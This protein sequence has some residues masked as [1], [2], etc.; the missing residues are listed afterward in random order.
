MMTIRPASI[1]DVVSMLV[2]EKQVFP[3][4]WTED[5]F[6]YELKENPYSFVFVA[7]WQGQI[8]GYI[9]W[10]QTFQTAQINNLAVHPQWQR[11]HVGETLLT[12]TLSRI[13]LAQ[14]QNITLEVRVSNLAAQK[15][16][17]KHGFKILLT[18]PAYYD[19][20]EDAYLMGKTI[21]DE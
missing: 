21:G 5:H 13:K 9:D 3:H 4:P 16:Y 8:I 6:Q 14:C 10:W 19:N 12:D 17:L 11:R 20:G 18:K 7:Q 15:L 1:E 2:I